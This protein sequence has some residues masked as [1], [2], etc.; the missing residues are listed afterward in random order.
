[1]VWQHNN[2]N[3]FK[4]EFVAHSARGTAQQSDVIGQKRCASVTKRNRE[5]ERPTGKKVAPVSNHA[6]KNTAFPYFRR[7]P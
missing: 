5:E 6:A 7:F 4:R 3:N 1:M 2:G